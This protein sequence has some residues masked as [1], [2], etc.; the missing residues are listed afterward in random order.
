MR[1]QPKAIHRIR[2]I[3]M[4]SKTGRDVSPEDPSVDTFTTSEKRAVLAATLEYNHT[5]FDHRH[6]EEGVSIEFTGRAPE[7]PRR[8]HSIPPV[9]RYHEETDSFADHSK[10]R[11]SASVSSS[12]STGTEASRQSS[13]SSKLN[14]PFGTPFSNGDLN[15]HVGAAHE[16]NGKAVTTSNGEVCI[17]A[18][19]N[20]D[21][22]KASANKGDVHTANGGVHKAITTGDGGVVGMLEVHVD[23]DPHISERT[24]FER[25]TKPP[26]STT[27]SSASD[28][29]DTAI[30][31]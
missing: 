16:P 4:R 15:H 19:S 13:V 28:T 17:T 25:D 24:G 31:T 27:L 5:H 23:S 30:H 21:P 8:F 20:G 26:L 11:R 1:R 14:E 6:Y 7:R 12:T 29:P 18:T 3:L 9:L 22:H 2:K 10:T